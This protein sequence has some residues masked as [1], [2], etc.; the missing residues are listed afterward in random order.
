MKASLKNVSLDESVINSQDFKEVV[1]DNID[2]ITEGIN[3]CVQAVKNPIVREILKISA[4][5][6]EG[7][8]KKSCGE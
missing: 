2:L 4:S 1:C 3:K 6:I 7:L 8:V 5:L